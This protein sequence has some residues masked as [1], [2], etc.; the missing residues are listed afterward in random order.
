MMDHGL[1]TMVLHYLLIYLHGI[2]VS[3]KTVKG[4]KVRKVVEITFEFGIR[5]AQ[6]ILTAVEPLLI[7]YCRSCV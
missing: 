5:V 4:K 6:P 1:H 7:R 2:D 3:C